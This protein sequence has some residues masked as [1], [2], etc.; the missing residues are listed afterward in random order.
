MAG[1]EQNKWLRKEDD[2]TWEAR[3]GKDYSY[4]NFREKNNSNKGKEI[5]KES[6][7]REFVDDVTASTKF[8]RLSLLSKLAVRNGSVKLELSR[9]GNTR[10]IRVFRDILKSH[11]PDLLF[12]SETLIVGN[13]IEEFSSNLDFVNFYLVSRQG[14]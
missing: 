1:R 13:K 10:T 4:H 5:I 8:H 3:I 11:K 12:L 14:Q 6:N 7:C 9:I 2:A